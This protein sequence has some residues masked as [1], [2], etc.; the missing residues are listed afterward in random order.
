MVRI[1]I[2]SKSNASQKK[3]TDLPLEINEVQLKQREDDCTQVSLGSLSDVHV[4]SPLPIPWKSLKSKGVS[5]E[6]DA[7][8]PTSQYLLAE[9]SLKRQ[10]SMQDDDEPDGMSGV[11]ISRHDPIMLALNKGSTRSKH[12]SSQSTIPRESLK[13]RRV[14][15]EADVSPSVSPSVSS[16]GYPPS[17]YSVAERSFKRRV[18]MDTVG[19]LDQVGILALNEGVPRDEFA[20]FIDHMIHLV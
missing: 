6:A 2:K 9:P 14:S 20:E 17:Q 4:S 1:T 3:S 13:C 7:P 12:V 19:M 11:G 8:H 18:T 5:M 16:V 15:M 10:V